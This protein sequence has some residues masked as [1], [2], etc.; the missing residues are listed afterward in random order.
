MICGRAREDLVAGERRLGDASYVLHTDAPVC[1]VRSVSAVQ[2]MYYK[3]A[4]AKRIGH[5]IDFLGEINLFLVLG[6]DIFYGNSASSV[7][8]R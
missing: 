1:A 5:T 2:A 6:R 3:S 4:C 7:F 8:T